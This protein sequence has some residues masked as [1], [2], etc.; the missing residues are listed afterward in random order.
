MYCMHEF[1]TEDGTGRY[2]SN[3]Y[4]ADGVED[5]GEDIFQRDVC[6]FNDNKMTDEEQDRIIEE[7]RVSF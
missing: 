3:A 4:I 7:I 2:R 5:V 6:L 1:V